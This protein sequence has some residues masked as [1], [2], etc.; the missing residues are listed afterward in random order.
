MAE[1]PVTIDLE[2]EEQKIE[3]E[4]REWSSNVIEVPN[5]NFNNIPTLSLR[6]G[7]LG[8]RIY[9]KIVFDHDGRGRA[10]LKKYLKSLDMMMTMT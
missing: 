7:S 2:E 9:V 6:Q 5:P 4:I 8:E 1:K 10:A 3:T